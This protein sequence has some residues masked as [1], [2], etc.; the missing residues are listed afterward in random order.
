V[1]DLPV[2]LVGTSR[3]SLGRSIQLERF[4]AA[5]DELQVPYARE[6]SENE[7]SWL[8]AEKVA[9]FLAN[10]S[11]AEMVAPVIAEEVVAEAEVDAEPDFVIEQVE[12]VDI[13]ALILGDQPD[14]VIVAEAV[15]DGIIVADAPVN[16][17]APVDVPEAEVVEVAEAEVVVEDVAAVPEVDAEPEPERVLVSSN[18]G[19]GMRTDEI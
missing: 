7:T 5:L 1:L 11:G 9:A 18:V 3:A 10:P 19:R 13:E 6:A 15:E 2:L 4:A 8:T 12:T 17:T 16:G 14:E